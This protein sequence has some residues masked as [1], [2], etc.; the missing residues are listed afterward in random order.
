MAND[1]RIITV[2]C[3]TTGH[4]AEL[5]DDGVDAAGKPKVGRLRCL[6]VAAKKIPELT[7]KRAGLP[8]LAGKRSFRAAVLKVDAAGK[9][10]YEPVKI[11][12]LFP[13]DEI[14]DAF[15]DIDTDGA[16]LA[17]KTAKQRAKIEEG[18]LKRDGGALLAQVGKILAT[19][20]AAVSMS[21]SAAP[22]A[23]GPP[24][25]APPGKEKKS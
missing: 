18:A 15:A 11:A 24:E 14:A 17:D 22:P 10:T 3:L 25:K 5:A 13:N 9:R 1:A 23:D 4:N 19:N 20:A 2:I 7:A 12:P 16:L 8:Q 21:G 6:E